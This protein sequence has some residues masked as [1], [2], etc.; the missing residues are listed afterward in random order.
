MNELSVNRQE[1]AA[2]IHNRILANGQIAA[3]ALV[4][5]C[6]DLKRMRDEKLYEE[7]NYSSFEDYAE[8]ACG[9]KQRQAY[10][11][12]AALE[13]LGAEY[14]EQNAELGIT[15]LE[16]ISQV[17]SFEREE[18]LAE[19]D[20][21]D[22]STRELKEEVQRFKNQ[23]EQLT[24]DLQ[25]A[26]DAKKELSE[27]LSSAEYDAGKLSAELED[28]KSKPTDV[29]VA[30][31]DD[32]AVKKA[33]EQAKA[34]DAELIKNLK[35]QVKDEKAKTKAAED[36]KASA[37]KDAKEK[38][39]KEANERIDKLVAE[40]KAKDAKLAEALKA[41]KVAGA[42]ED[43]IAVRIL[44]A[45]LQ[46]TANELIKHINIIREKDAEKADKLSAAISKTMLSLFG[47][48]E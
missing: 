33:V 5:M 10:S 1:Q 44:F 3:Q 21:E 29:I 8:Q 14:I 11:Y 37:V 23:V 42:D 4:A 25:E 27:K 24:L 30:E 20:V 34:E 12:I 7:L 46:S 6:Q 45:D 17:S 39:V 40:S 48:V 2:L 35:Q 9:I 26:E 31:P 18:F 32:E 16:L 41:A 22:I 36:G 15:K 47:G 19:V 28:I 38:A 13:R 43:T